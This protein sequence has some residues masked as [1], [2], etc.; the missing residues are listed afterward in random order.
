M[1]NNCLDEVLTTTEAGE[2]WE[3]PGDTVKRAA[4]QGR[5]KAKKSGWVWLTTRT[6]MKE[7]FGDKPMNLQNLLDYIEKNA[8]DVSDLADVHKI[9]TTESGDIYRNSLIRQIREKYEGEAIA[10]DRAS[11]FEDKN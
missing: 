2:L 3:L 11:V 9:K 8:R 5:L 6:A 7:Y 4:L 10:A 1:S